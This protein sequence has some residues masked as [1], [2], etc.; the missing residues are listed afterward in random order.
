[1]RR[2]VRHGRSTERV[3]SVQQEAQEAELFFRDLMEVA[4]PG[5]RLRGGGGSLVSL[6][7]DALEAVEV[8]RLRNPVWNMERDM[9]PEG[10]PEDDEEAWSEFDAEFVE[11]D[12]SPNGA[13]A[14]FAPLLSGAGHWPIITSHSQGRIVSYRT[15]SGT[16][17]GRQG[18]S[19]GANRSS[20]TR[21]HVG[22]DL[23]GRFGDSVV[24]IE[25]GR[26][27]R[28]FP[29]C[30]G[31]NKTSWALLVQHANVVVNY[32]EVVPDS[33]SRHGLRVGSTVRAGQVIARVGR[34]PGGSSMIH[35]ETYTTGTTRSHRWMKGHTRPAPVLNP[36][37]LLLQLQ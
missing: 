12:S 2:R 9:E 10:L 34:N 28:F 17:L 8:P 24:A 18:R 7:R 14:P 32:G 26:I 33:L 30:C 21:Y 31:E 19:F 35:F 6:R 29:F 1:M 37:H 5:R 3:W 20:G 22:V 11:P 36:T 13:N 23:F 25:D 4:R 15:L 16:W 27:V